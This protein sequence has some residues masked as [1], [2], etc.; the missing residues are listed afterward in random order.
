MRSEESSRTVGAVIARVLEDAAFIFTD[1]LEPETHPSAAWTAD[2][3][4][5]TF[6]GERS[7]SFRLWADEGFVSLLAE[8]M[9]GIVPDDPTAQE[10]KADAFKELVNIIA[11]NSLTE[12]FGTTAVFELG[13][14]QR[15]DGATREAD[16]VRADAIRLQ[17]EGNSLVCVVDIEDK[18]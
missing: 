10:K 1:E 12:L 16:C 18:G 9:L 15:A 13:I 17:A 14:P 3:V 2:G 7:G 8:N 4:S 6:S 5:L 11:G